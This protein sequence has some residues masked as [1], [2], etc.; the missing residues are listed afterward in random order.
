D[1]LRHKEVMK[2]VMANPGKPISITFRTL[3]KDGHYLWVESIAV[4][5]MDDPT[6]HAVVVNMQDISDRKKSEEANK[7]NEEKYRL[8]IE[9]ISDGFIALDKDLRYTYANKKIGDMTGHPPEFLIGK[10]VWDV[11][12]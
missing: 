1:L 6:L 11:F 2:E 7:K 8:L 3:H 10:I 5:R 12:P 9:R 4:N